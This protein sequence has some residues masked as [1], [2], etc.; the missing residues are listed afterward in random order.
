MVTTGVPQRGQPPGLRSVSAV[1]VPAG[2]AVVTIDQAFGDAQTRK[3]LL[4][5]CQVFSL[6]EVLEVLPAHGDASPQNLLIESNGGGAEGSKDFAVI[7][8][9][10]YRGACAGVD[11]SIARLHIREELF[12]PGPLDGSFA[13]G[14]SA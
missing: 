6:E 11:L 13:S 10:M 9:G 1:P 8:W 5:R 7:D 4:L 12:H 14:G 2:H 3:R